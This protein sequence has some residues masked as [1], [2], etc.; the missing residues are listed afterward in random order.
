MRFEYNFT[1]ISMKV[2]SHLPPLTRDCILLKDNMLCTFATLV[3]PWPLNNIWVVG[4]ILSELVIPAVSM[5][6][7]KLLYMYIGLLQVNLKTLNFIKALVKKYRL[8]WYLEDKVAFGLLRFSHTV[9]LIF[10]HISC[11]I[12]WEP[13]TVMSQ[14]RDSACLSPF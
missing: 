6:S 10:W 8:T 9:Y 2:W 5:A 7:R 4:A 13:S 1:C 12:C 11:S 3:W 14:R